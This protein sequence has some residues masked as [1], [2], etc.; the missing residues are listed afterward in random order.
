MRALL[1]LASPG[2]KLGAG[3][4][5]VRGALLICSILSP[6]GAAVTA[7]KVVTEYLD[8]PDLD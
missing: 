7:L 5:G 6:S 2:E 4:R 3:A 8:I 1:F